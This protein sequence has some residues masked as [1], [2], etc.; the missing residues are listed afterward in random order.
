[1]AEFKTSPGTFLVRK[2]TPKSSTNDLLK[3][4]LMNFQIYIFLG[5]F[6]SIQS[7]LFFKDETPP[8]QEKSAIGDLFVSALSLKKTPSSTVGST[9]T[10]NTTTTTPLIRSPNTTTNAYNFKR[11]RGGFASGL[12]STFLFSKV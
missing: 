8:S 11:T 2:T 9:S 4:S 6:F 10:T 5:C 3:F 1:M 7:N 12:Q